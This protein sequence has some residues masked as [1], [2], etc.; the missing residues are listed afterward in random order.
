MG[1]IDRVVV[2]VAT[3]AYVKGQ[4]R[5]GRALGTTRLVSWADH[6]P[7]YSPSH[8]AAPYAFKAWALKAAAELHGGRTLLWADACILPIAPVE[9]LWERIERD[10]YW[11]SNNGYTNAEWTVPEAYADLGVTPEENEAIPHVVATTFGISLDHP[12]GRAIL[13]EY[14]RLAQTKAFCGPVRLRQGTRVSRGDMEI[15]GHRHDQTALSV[16]AWRNGCKLTNP[17]EVFCY[18]GGETAETLLV[19]DGAY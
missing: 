15:S 2:N 3:G 10:G 6:M 12:T 16:I 17:P 1:A 8:Q 14:L 7:M 11:I 18:K 13:D 19:A 4:Q 9:P 5:L